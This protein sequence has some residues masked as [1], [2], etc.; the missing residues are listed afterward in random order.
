[1]FT[2]GVT[3]AQNA[4]GEEFGDERLLDVLRAQRGSS[5]AAIERAVVDAV[6]AFSPGELTDDATLVVLTAG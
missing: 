4:A 1:M 3:E 5:A 2:D 6:D